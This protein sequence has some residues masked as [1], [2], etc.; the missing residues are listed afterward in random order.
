M[1]PSPF[2]PTRRSVLE[3]LGD[4]DQQVRAGAYDLL[5]RSYWQPIYVYHRLR[6]KLDPSDA[7]DAT[8]AFL[9]AAWTKDYFLGFDPAKARFRTF[10]RVCLDR[11]IMRERERAG[12]LKRGGGSTMLA[13]DFAGVESALSTDQPLA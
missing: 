10:L 1:A 7:E 9:T 12:A 11:F 3:L 6:W 2:P 13:L 4:A 5:I 8:Q